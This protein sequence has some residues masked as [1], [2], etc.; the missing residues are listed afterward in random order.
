MRHIRRFSSSTVRLSG[1]TSICGSARRKATAVCL[2]VCLF[3]KRWM[4]GGAFTGTV[5]PTITRIQSTRRGRLN[6]LPG[7]YAAE[8]W[9]LYK[10]YVVKAHGACMGRI[11]ER[12]TADMKG[13][14]GLTFEWH[15]WASKREDDRRFKMGGWPAADAE[16]AWGVY[17]L[18]LQLHLQSE[19]QY[20][21]TG[22][23]QTVLS[24]AKENGSRSPPLLTGICA[25]F[26]QLCRNRSCSLRHRVSRR[27]AL[28]LAI[29]HHRCRP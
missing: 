27:L 8:T 26:I 2:R 12:Q 28:H 7:R 23:F 1:R 24:R 18:P 11:N 17:P 3:T 29:R 25:V 9:R 13:A 4:K 20:C 21:P 15:E 22:L 6:T 16:R 5:L 10:E 14:G 19:E